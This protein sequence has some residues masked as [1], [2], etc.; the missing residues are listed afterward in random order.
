MSFLKKIL[1]KNSLAVKKNTIKPQYLN[2]QYIYDLIAEK[3]LHNA[4][5]L[6]DQY[7]NSFVSEDLLE[8]GEAFF[9]HQLVDHALI[10]FKKASDQN[11][12]IA[13]EWLG[14]I[15]QHLYKFK[16]LD[17]AQKYYFESVQ[18]GNIHA[19]IGLADLYIEESDYI[20][21]E[22][23]YEF[24]NLALSNNL[25]QALYYQGKYHAER[26]EYDLSFH[27]FN[28]LKDY[29]LLTSS[30]YG[31][32]LLYYHY[33]NSPYY[34]PQKALDILEK[35]IEKGNEPERFSFLADFYIAETPYRNEAQAIQLYSIGM[36][37]GC[38][39]SENKIH[40]L[41]AKKFSSQ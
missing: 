15:Y 1:N 7:Q 41:R 40:K 17:L 19:Y 32:S 4:L 2:G 37:Q 35:T 14:S 9:D 30:A 11:N 26:G 28:K 6:L 20:D 39:Y 38:L 27:A 22:K 16:N 36:Q 24:S 33:K 12:A 8:F 23:S 21:L 3:R 29:D 31:L 5:D 10:Y 13:Y 34:N 25:F 18:L